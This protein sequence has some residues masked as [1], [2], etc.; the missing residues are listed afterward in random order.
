MGINCYECGY[1]ETHTGERV[2]IPSQVED[3]PFCGK[4]VLNGSNPTVEVPMGGCCFAFKIEDVSEETGDKVFYNRFGGS[5]E[6]EQPWFDNTCGE[7]ADGYVCEQ[8]TI[9]GGGYDDEG[10]VCHCFEN[11]C[12]TEIEDF[13]GKASTG[14]VNLS[15]MLALLSVIKLFL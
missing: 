1:M 7:T 8:K 10:R 14:M 4:D 2:K 6:P 15:L 3:I 13:T 12:N 11:L 9:K 5:N